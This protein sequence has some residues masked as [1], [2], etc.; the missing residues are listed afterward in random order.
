[1]TLPSHPLFSST[2]WGLR[3]H[4]APCMADS[5]RHLNGCPRT[6]HGRLFAFAPMSIQHTDGQVGLWILQKLASAAQNWGCGAKGCRE[7]NL[8]GLSAVTVERPKQLRS[9]HPPPPTSK[10]LCD[11]GL[12]AGWSHQSPHSLP[13]F[14]TV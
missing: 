10:E 3:L 5:E 4:N 13:Q 2:R 7:E 11:T 9:A 6:S 14:N 12:E 1:M 8:A